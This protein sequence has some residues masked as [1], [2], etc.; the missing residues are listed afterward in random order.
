MSH[1]PLRS[2]AARG[3]TAVEVLLAM[4][5]MAIGAAAVM[6]MQKASIQGNLDARETDVAN[7]IARTWVERLQ[8]DGMQW[9]IPGPSNPGANPNL[10]TT[11]LI[12]QA[13]AGNQGNWFAPTQYLA[14]GISPGFDILGRD[15]PAIGDLPNALFCANVRL[16][17]LS[18][19]NDLARA[20]VRVLW[21]RAFNTGRAGDPCSQAT[22]NQPDPTVYHALYVTTAV[23]GNPQ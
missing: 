7:S 15:I 8:A 18:Q 6:S 2:G 19:G 1:V 17:W 22:N 21:A 4:T 3:F 16:T 13:G 11:A 9:T 5:V 14:A 12:L 10:A 20:D 23:Q